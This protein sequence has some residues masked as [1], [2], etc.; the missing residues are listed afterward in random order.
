MK[1][2]RKRPAAD[3]PS[4]SQAFLVRHRFRDLDELAQVARAW[5]ID[6]RRVGRGP[7][8]GDVIQ[9]GSE[10]VHLGRARLRRSVHQTGS[11]P[12]GYRTFAIPTIR[13]IRLF[14]RGHDIGRDQIMVFPRSRELDCASHPDFDMLTVSL[15]QD[16]LDDAAER[17]GLHSFDR[18]LAGREVLSCDSERLSR[19]RRWLLQ[20]LRVAS[21]TGRAINPERMASVFTRLVASSPTGPHADG[22]ATWQRAEVVRGRRRDD[23]MRRA[24]SLIDRVEPSLFSVKELAQVAGCSPRTLR[25]VFTE[26]FGVGPKS[27]VLARRLTGARRELRDADPENTIIA[28]IANRWGFWHMG[29][30]AADYRLFFGELPSTTLGH[31]T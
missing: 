22:T 9:M 20:L 26:R 25:R 24:L 10:R 7:F 27:Y 11:T 4:E 28:D 2:I 17:A 3:F 12:A 18:C 5:D 1:G 29:Q 19:T 6:F 23:A 30:F 13:D 8:E 16:D 14:W 15:I 31:R 21:E